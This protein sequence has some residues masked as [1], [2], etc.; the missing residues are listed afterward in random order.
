MLKNVSYVCQAVCVP[1]ESKL[2]KI[3]IVVLF[4]AVSSEKN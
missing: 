2:N 4:M 3:M 1:G